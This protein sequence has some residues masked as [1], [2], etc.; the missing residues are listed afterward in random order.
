MTVHFINTRPSLHCDDTL[1]QALALLDIKS[2]RLPLLSLCATPHSVQKQHLNKLLDGQYTLLVVVS[3]TAVHY[4]KHHLDPQMLKSLQA[5][6]RQNRLT[7]VA[8]G[9][10]TAKALADLGIH[11]QTPE[12]MSNEGMIQM[13]HIQHLLHAPPPKKALFW[14]GAGGRTVLFDTLVAHGVQVDSTVWY[15]RRKPNHLTHDLNQLL[16][17]IHPHEHIFVLISSEMAFSHWQQTAKPTHHAITYLCLGTRLYN[18]VGQEK[19]PRLRLNNLSHDHLIATLT[20]Q[21]RQ[22][23][24]PITY[25]QAD[26]R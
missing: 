8:V 21:I 11:A 23:S 12:H 18:L 4:A 7:V 22:S 24:A 19:L 15:E 16:N 25:H 6:I 17:T 5:Q 10:G 26:S 9:E 3:I 14:R 13:S 1:T 20:Q 2:H